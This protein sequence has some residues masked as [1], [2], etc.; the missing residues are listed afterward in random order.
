MD[1]PLAYSLEELTWLKA[2]ELLDLPPVCITYSHQAPTNIYP[3]R[4]HPQR[5]PY[6]STSVTRAAAAA[7]RPVGDTHKYA[8]GCPERNYLAAHNDFLD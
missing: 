8:S 2:S 5:R 7:P 1:A 3:V 6:L 4:P